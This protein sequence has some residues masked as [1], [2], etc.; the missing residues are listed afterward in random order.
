MESLERLI[1]NGTPLWNH[2]QERMINARVKEISLDRYQ[3][4]NLPC[5]MSY[6]VT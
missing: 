6:V 2:L 3:C 4:G 1:D 5:S